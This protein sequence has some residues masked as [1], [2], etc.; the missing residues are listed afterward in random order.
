VAATQDQISSAQADPQRLQAAAAQ[1]ADAVAA[2]Q[3]ELTTAQADLTAPKA[4]AKKAQDAVDA[5]QAAIAA[6]NAQ[7]ANLLGQLD[8]VNGQIAAK[9]AISDF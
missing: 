3:A 9:Q 6:A 5:N 7:I 1:A 8:T 2:K 4:A